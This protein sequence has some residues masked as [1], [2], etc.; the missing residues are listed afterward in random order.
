MRAKLTDKQRQ[1]I[2]HLEGSRREG[3]ALR[4]YARGH[5]LALSELY[6]PLAALGRGVNGYV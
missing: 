2:E 6:D 1:A 3:V 4:A 5:G